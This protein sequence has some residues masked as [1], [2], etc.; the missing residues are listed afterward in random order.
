MPFWLKTRAR[1]IG[2]PPF[3]CQQHREVSRTTKVTLE[4]QITRIKASQPLVSANF[5][6]CRF[7]ICAAEPKHFQASLS[8][9]ARRYPV[10]EQATHLVD[11]FPCWTTQC[12]EA[13]NYLASIMIT[14]ASR[15]GLD[16]KSSMLAW[17]LQERLLLIH[18]HQGR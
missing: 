5:Y 4:M 14:N 1:L 3:I 10:H 17:Q 8:L 12:N 2:S 18:V 11:G 16:N 13:S 9:K 7:H 6:T 15:N